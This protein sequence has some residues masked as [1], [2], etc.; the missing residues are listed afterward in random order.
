MEAYFNLTDGTYLIRLVIAHIA[1]DYI[2]Q[3]KSMVEAKYNK[4]YKSPALYF[5]CLVSVATSWLALDLNFGFSLW[6]A[7]SIGIS[8]FFID[9]AKIKLD[10]NRTFIAFCLD[11]LAHM[12]VIV[13]VW[14]LL[15]EKFSNLLEMVKG[16]IHDYKFL[17]I[18]LGYLF[19]IWPASYLIKF[20]ISSLHLSATPN[21]PSPTINPLAQGSVATN[22][23]SQLQATQADDIL[24]NA[25][26]YIGIFERVIIL[27]LVLYGEYEAIG[28]LITGKSIVRMNSTKQTEY[29]LAGTLLSYAIAILTGVMINWIIKFI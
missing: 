9:I 13:I 16:Y 22:A 2:F 21:P 28:F 3:S 26:K 25:G 8:H 5:H 23:S 14:L 24:M 18:V 27:T 19:I 1:T 29:V 20:A 15:I 6:L 7:I 12:I 11:Q 4:A 10:K 17:L